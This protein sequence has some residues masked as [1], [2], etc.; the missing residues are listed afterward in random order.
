M[1]FF[2]IGP[3]RMHY[4]VVEDIFPHDSLLLHGNLGANVWWEPALAEFARLAAGKSYSGRAILGEWRG[5]GKSSPP[6]SEAELAMDVLAGDYLALTKHLRLQRPH[7][8]GH[9]L[10]GMLA[11]R[12]LCRAGES[13]GKAMLL[14]P[15][16]ATGFF[17]NDK[18]LALIDR[19]RADRRLCREVMATTI[20]N[21]HELP[22]EL[23]ER[24]TDAA[25]HT[26]ELNWRG[27]PNQIASIDI[28]EELKRVENPVL[29]IHGMLAHVVG[30]E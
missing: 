26:G 23:L 3:Q 21:V 29:V 8:V 5:C 25:F 15:L 30:A 24:I 28:R 4:E 7:L 13:Y 20:V 27:I 1:P 18:K 10:G 22:L 14:N 6:S 2:E 16:P 17:T 12:L 19:M 9:S 11:Q